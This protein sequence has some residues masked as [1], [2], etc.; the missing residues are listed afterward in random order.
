MWYLTGT[1]PDH[2]IPT[3]TKDIWLISDNT[4]KS[5]GNNFCPWGEG[6]QIFLFIV[7]FNS[8]TKISIAMF[9]FW[10]VHIRTVNYASVF[11]TQNLRFCCFQMNLGRGM[12]IMVWQVSKECSLP[13]VVSW[14]FPWLSFKGVDPIFLGAVPEKRLLARMVFQV[15]PLDFYT[16]NSRLGVCAGSSSLSKVIKS[17]SYHFLGVLDISPGANKHDGLTTFCCEQQP[18]NV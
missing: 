1:V 2:Y 7:G 9:A 4:G 16:W 10:N 13:W 15:N 12:F 18:V 8:P 6:T 14:G 5:L 17:R 11:P 3:Y